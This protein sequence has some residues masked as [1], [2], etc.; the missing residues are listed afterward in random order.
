MFNENSI[1]WILGVTTVGALIMLIGFIASRNLP[2]GQKKLRVQKFAAVALAL[3]AFSLPI[4]KPFISSYSR[5]ESLDELKAESLY[6]V[7]EIA[8][9]D[10]EQTRNI[11]RLKNE[12]KDLR[13]ELDAVNTYY[14]AVTQ[15]ISTALAVICLNFVFR[16]RKEELEELQPDQLSKL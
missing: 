14:G 1:Y 15:L 7:D 13:N 16:R 10:K 3:V 8:K 2:T 11:E 5:T 12:V 4:F 9:F 6:S